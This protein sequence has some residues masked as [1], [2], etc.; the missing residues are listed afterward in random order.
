MDDSLLERWFTL[1]LN[2]AAT[3]TTGH[4]DSPADV[5]TQVST[6]AARLGVSRVGLAQHHPGQL[7]DVLTLPDLQ[8]HTHPSVQL[9][10]CS[11]CQKGDT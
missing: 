9:P 4:A 8:T 10:I 7:H 2:G 5:D 1:F 3:D 11:V 6:D